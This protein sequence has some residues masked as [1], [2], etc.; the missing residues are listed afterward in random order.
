MKKVKFFWQQTDHK[1]VCV[2]IFYGY[3]DTEISYSKDDE[4][5]EGRGAIIKAS[6]I[7]HS[8]AKQK[9]ESHG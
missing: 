5:N 8:A 1:C 7:K 4:I 3:D 9:K 2:T 6:L